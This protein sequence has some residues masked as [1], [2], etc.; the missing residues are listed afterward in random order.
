MTPSGENLLLIE[1]SSA[2]RKRQ[3]IFFFIYFIFF[4]K[5]SLY[6]CSCVFMWRTDSNVIA[7]VA[8]NELACTHY[9]RGPCKVGVYVR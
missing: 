8:V 4:T 1:M 7:D 3:Y 2:L 6:C 9:R 5:W